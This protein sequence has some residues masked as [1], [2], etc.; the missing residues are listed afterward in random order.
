VKL[1]LIVTAKLCPG[2]PEGGFKDAIVAGGLIVKADELALT[3]AK[4][5]LVV[6]ETV[7]R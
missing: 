3:K 7:T 5:W 1:P 2:W 6:P 4:P